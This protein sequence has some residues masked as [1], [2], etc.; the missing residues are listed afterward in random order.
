[1]SVPGAHIFILCSPGIDTGSSDLWVISDACVSNCST[2]PL[3]PQATLQL[4]GLD[5]HL[6]YGDSRTGTHAFG[7]IGKDNVGLAGLSLPNQYFA[8]VNDTNTSVV[9]AG[10]AGIFGLGF[11]IIR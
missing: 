2:G 9:D 3:Y 7:P 8:A 5:A 6:L 10:S 4:T 1:V 11:P